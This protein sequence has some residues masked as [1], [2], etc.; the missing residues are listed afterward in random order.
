MSYAAY[1]MLPPFIDP[2]VEGPNKYQNE[3]LGIQYNFISVLHGM[4]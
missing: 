4:N 1:N 2:P 3:I